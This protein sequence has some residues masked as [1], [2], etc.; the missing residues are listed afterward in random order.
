MFLWWYSRGWSV[1]IH[2]LRSLFANITDF[3]SMDSLL[4]T[5]F[6]PFRQI[7]ASSAHADSS[8]DLKFHMF[9][10]RLVSRFIGFSTRLILLIIGLFIII[11][12]SIVSLF[13]IIIWPL[14]PFAPIAGIILSISG[15]AP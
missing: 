13:L 6:Q 7:S 11:V 15:V 4:R 10:D 9:L 2:K 5:L 14:I 3:F 12:G 1:F 8:L